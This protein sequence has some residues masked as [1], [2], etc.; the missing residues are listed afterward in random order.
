LN[1][2]KALHHKMQG[3]FVHFAHKRRRK[4]ASGHLQSGMTLFY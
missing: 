2:E 1:K 3:F 4:K